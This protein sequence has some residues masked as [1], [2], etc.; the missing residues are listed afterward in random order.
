VFASLPGCS[1]AHFACH[2]VSNPGDPSRSMLFL[3]DHEAAPLNVASLF[4]VSHDLLRLVYLSACSTTQVSDARLLDEA[5]HL[6]SAFQLAGSRHVIGTLWR[7]D[8]ETAIDVAA[9]FYRKLKTEADTLDTDR[10]ARA[11]HQVVLSARDG[12]APSLWATY[13]HAGA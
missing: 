8:G 3:H 12:R 6:T 13:L 11:L 2:A 10:A 4:P 9:A 1:V 5:I 7:I